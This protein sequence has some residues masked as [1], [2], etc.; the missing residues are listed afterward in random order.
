[1]DLKR[2]VK[3]DK[4][5]TQAIDQK[6]PEWVAYFPSLSRATNKQK[7][8]YK[9]WFGEFERGIYVDVVGNLSYIY[10][11][12]Y[13]IID[14]FLSDKNIDGLIESFEKIKQ[15]Y[16]NYKNIDANLTYWMRDAFYYLGDYNNAWKATKGKICFLTDLLN[17][18]AK[19]S[20]KSIDADD[21]ISVINKTYLGLTKFGLEH[22]SQV[23]IIANNY[24]DEFHKEHGKN[25]IEYFIRRFNTQDLTEDDFLQLKH[26]FDDKESFQKEK[27]QYFLNQDRYN[28]TVQEASDNYLKFS[29]I[30][31][32]D[33]IV[34]KSYKSSYDRM[35]KGRNT[36]ERS[37]FSNAIA[38][39]APSV[40]EDAVPGIVQS[41]LQNEIK[42]IFRG[43]E[44]TLREE[45]SLPK[46]RVRKQ[47]K[48]VEVKGMGY[49]NKT[50]DTDNQNDLPLLKRIIRTQA[51][52][53]T[54]KH[55][56]DRINK[57]RLIT[58][59]DF[60]RQYVWKNDAKLKSRL[61]ESVFLEV[62][63]P[64]IYTAEEE[65]GS[66][67]VI[68]GQQRL[69][70]FSNFLNNEFKL[71]GLEVCKELNHKSFKT[72]GDIDPTY[73]EKIENYPL[74]VIKILKDS[75][76]TVRFDIFERLNRGSVKLNDQ[77]L[78]NCIYRGPFNDFIKT[79]AKDTDF[80][81]LI[82]SKEQIRMQDAELVL[83]FITF[84]DR[85]YLKFKS[86]MKGFLTNFMSDYRNIDSSKV[87][88]FKKVFRQAVN[89]VKTVFG[90]KAFY[91]YS[92]KDSSSGKYENVIN[93]GLF[94]VLMNGFTRYDQHQV[95]PHKDAIKEE[96]FWLMTDD[97]FL[98][99]IT[100]AGTDSTKKLEKKFD[101]WLNS[102]KTILGYPK[103]ET[104]LFSWE[105]KKG[106]WGKNPVCSICK[107]KI[108]QLD[109]SEVDHIEFYWRGG[110]TIP[111]NARLSHRFC[112]RSRKKK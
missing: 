7:K 31:G 66:E 78:R 90:E 53:P 42:R 21:V 43:F 3:L 79:V 94:D 11:Y 96:L 87:N 45:M 26:Y 93:K 63:I 4:A 28:K 44:N 50:D 48:K 98:D 10:V 14:K 110:N 56:C 76:F 81:I 2:A 33:N 67:V 23:K 103:S 100:G 22:I 97:K 84:Y 54:I 102:L 52:D 88:E 77:E 35:I 8:F 57:G 86:P 25:L 112:N 17:I 62:P 49:Q 92:N 60:Q 1:M 111:E 27:S 6:V 34:T 69:M 107:Q 101:I 5:R 51:S 75:D 12:I 65:D 24:L 32:E 13:T 89:L 82:G 95:M 19:C 15:G 55:L 38:A 30:Y 39:K 71:T 64:T 108:E 37:F 104:R 61:I 40:R 105:F 68:D 46:I 18:K 59:A 9:Y 47:S 41:A 85:T 80:Q 29:K 74:R 36:Y 83:R 20:D 73:Q 16:G 72:L 106:L 109:D 70:T 91:L 99:V 58:Q